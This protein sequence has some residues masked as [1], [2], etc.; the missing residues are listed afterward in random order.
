M[1]GCCCAQPRGGGRAHLPAQDV[2]DFHVVVVHDAGEVVGGKAVRLEEHLVVDG[3]VGK[4]HVAADRVLDHRGPA[5][6]TQPH[7]VRLPRRGARLRLAGREAEA[8]P[9]VHGRRADPGLPL[10]QRV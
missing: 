1:S 7:G 8:V 4:G 6:H 2:G 9:V 5:G 3:A 10:A